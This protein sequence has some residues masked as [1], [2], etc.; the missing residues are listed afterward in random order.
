MGVQISKILPKNEI[1]L[2]DL[3]G[4]TLAVDAFLWLH[5]FLS[6]IR[7]RDGVP[8]KD[9]K[10]RITS[11]LSGLFY[12]SA[13]L[14]ENNINLVWVFDGDKPDLKTMTIEERKEI[15][16]ESYKKWQEALSLG[17]LQE[18]RKYAQMSSK[19]TG[20][21]IEESKKLLEYMGIQ[22]VQ[23]PSEGEAQ[24]AHLCQK[25]QVYSVASQD[26]DSLL[27]NTP[28]L[29]RNL[30]ITGKKRL[31]RQN[32]YVEIKPELIELKS[33][34]KELGINRK[35]LVIIGILVGSDYNPGIKGIGPKRALSLVKKEKTLENVLKKIEWDYNT[36]A[37]K[38]YDFY[39][40]PP[41]NDVEIETKQVNPDKIFKFMVD[42]HDFS[43]D[44]IEKV[45][46][47][48]TED[49]QKSL[50]SWLK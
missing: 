30:S 22:W 34:L 38:V 5:Q 4:K 23:A 35:Q 9:S 21:M 33:V 40:N 28:K 14:L 11:H 36:P 42:E 6:I 49:R 29:I 20:E 50:G 10:G 46:K 8:L 15:R 2:K 25:G 47:S 44:R 18:A 7:Q 19:L 41:V 39:L 1:E 13:K 26:S 27:F 37:Q 16:E 3:S 24:C 17:N 12:R 45:V 48:L 32:I 31:P 43:H